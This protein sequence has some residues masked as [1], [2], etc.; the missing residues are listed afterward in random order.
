MAHVRRSRLNAQEAQDVQAERRNAAQSW[1]G[2]VRQRVEEEVAHH[3]ADHIGKIAIV[4]MIARR[5]LNRDA[6]NR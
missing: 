6:D 4:A 3:T 5:V 2:N 1:P